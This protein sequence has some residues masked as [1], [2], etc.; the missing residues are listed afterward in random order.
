MGAAMIMTIDQYMSRPCLCGR[1]RGAHVHS[2]PATRVAVAGDMA[3]L[4]VVTLDGDCL[5]FV[6]EIERELGGDPRTNR[7]LSEILR[8]DHPELFTAATAEDA[9][10]RSRSPLALPDESEDN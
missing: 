2:F 1:P 6:D 5:G 7:H 10:V 9:D 8:R 3:G 4:R